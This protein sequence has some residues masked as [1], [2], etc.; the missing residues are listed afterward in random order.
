MPKLKISTEV[1]QSLLS[2]YRSEAISAVVL[3]GKILFKSREFQ[4]RMPDD[5]A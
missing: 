2:A 1:R 3:Q 5:I 4:F